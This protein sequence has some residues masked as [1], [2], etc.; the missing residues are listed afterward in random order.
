MVIMKIII[1]MLLKQ[2]A[3]NPLIKERLVPKPY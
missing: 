2:A 1:G 3:H